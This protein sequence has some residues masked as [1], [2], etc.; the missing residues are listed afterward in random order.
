MKKSFN[1]IMICA[2]Q[3]AFA[4]IA[5]G[6]ASVTTLPA[7]TTPNPSISLEFGD[8]AGPQLGRGIILP[9]VNSASAVVNSVEG[10]FFYDV[11]DKIVKLKNGTNSYFNLSKNEITTVG[12]NPNFDTTGVVSTALQDAPNVTESPDAKVSI[13]P[14]TSS[15]P[16]GIL[17]LE[18]A[19]QAMILP[20]VASPH[21]NI[22]NPEPG[23]MAYDTVT[24]QIAV[25]NG[26]VWSFWKP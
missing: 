19:N 8:Y 10:T 20:K 2:A 13:G 9:Y 23:M 7:S 24:K 22:I 21:L 25:Y 3:L 26:K 17:V 16:P 1:I 4:Q 11:T 18:N 15:T 14:S 5:I 12:L 6:K